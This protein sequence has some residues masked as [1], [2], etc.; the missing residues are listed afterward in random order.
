MDFYNNGF[1]GFK[2]GVLMQHKRNVKMYSFP[3]GVPL[4]QHLIV[5]L[6]FQLDKEPTHKAL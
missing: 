3:L 1:V 5:V 6:D 4:E 2:N